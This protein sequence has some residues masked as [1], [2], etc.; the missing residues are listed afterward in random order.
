LAHHTQIDLEST[1]ARRDPRRSNPAPKKDDFV[2]ESSSTQGA[3]MRPKILAS[4]QDTNSE[5]FVNL[6]GAQMIVW[7]NA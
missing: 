3:S 4:L 5:I 2:F 1:R 6:L 7:L